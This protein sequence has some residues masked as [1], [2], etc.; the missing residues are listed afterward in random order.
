MLQSAWHQVYTAYLSFFGWQFLWSLP[1]TSQSTSE[2][3]AVPVSAIQ[4]AF[5]VLLKPSFP[6][7]EL[8]EKPMNF[9][10]DYLA[11]YWF[12]IMCWCSGKS[13]PSS[14][15]QRLESDQIYDRGSERN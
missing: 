14:N 11:V 13:Q 3:S 12:H 1:E 7:R 2:P 8:P 4:L 6:T 9:L 15:T 5:F 10:D